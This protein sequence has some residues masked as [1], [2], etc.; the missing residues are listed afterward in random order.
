MTGHIRRRGSRSWELKFDVGTDPLTGRRKTRFTSFKGT[1][2]EAE[3][4]LVRLINAEHIG[5]AVDPSRVTVAEFLERWE[6][7]WATANVS[8]KTLERYSGLLHKQVIPNIGMA[9][10]QRLRPVDLTELYAKLL[11]EGR[12]ADRGLSARTV[13]HVHRVIH[14]ALGHAARWGVVQANVAA[15]VDPPRV[16]SAEIE[17]LSADAIKAILAKLRGRTLRPIVLMALGT[18]ARRGE[19]LALRWQD[20]DLDRAVAR[21]ERSLEQTKAGLRFKEPKTR[22]GRR[23]IALPAYLVAELRTHWRAQQELNL[24]MGAGKLAPDALVFPTFNGKPRSPNAVTKEWSVAS[25]A[26]GV[27]ATFHAL[28]HTHASQLIASGLDVLTISRRLGHGSPTVTLGVYGH[29]F[30]N[31]DERVTQALEMAF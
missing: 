20:I 15:L 4:E 5:Q 1:K 18:G 21:I 9:R 11:R 31:T 10:I 17:I 6:R 13:T 29:L 8:P 12:A 30:S 24:A 14:R 28:R 19:L 7:D 16:A 22:H 23:S 27:S 3:A 25:K 26:A 2:R